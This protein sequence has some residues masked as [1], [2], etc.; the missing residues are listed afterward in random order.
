MIADL[1]GTTALVTGGASGIGGGVCR[2]LATQGA[3]VGVADMNL[4]GAEDAVREIEEAGGAA[5]AL[6]MDVTDPASVRS[7]VSSAIGS[8]GKIDTLVN[9][10]GVIG[11]PGWQDRLEVTP[12]DW[13]FTFDVNVRGVVNATE[14][15]ETHMA[16]RGSGSIVN[17]SSIAGKV[18]NPDRSSYNASKAAV[19]SYTQSMA[20]RLARHGVTVN[21]VCPGMIWT[22]MWEKISARQFAYGSEVFTDL[23]EAETN[24]ELFDRLIEFSTPLGR[25]QAPEDIGY[26]VAFL[27]S[28]QAANITGQSLNVD[29]GRVMS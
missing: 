16:E 8:L 6:Q 27:V 23:G 2:I 12:E 15:V 11:A 24:R 7:A 28:E 29:G 19:I 4:A 26:A 9:N 5:T 13:S 21:C 17:I 14:A 20:L 1:S 18:G 22:P 25:P 3:V 10:A